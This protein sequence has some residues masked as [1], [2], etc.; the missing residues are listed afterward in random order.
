VPRLPAAVSSICIRKQ[1]WVI[2]RDHMQLTV[3]SCG[4]GCRLLTT[5]Q[6]TLVRAARS[7]KAAAVRVVAVQ[8]QHML[9]RLR[10][11]GCWLHCYID[12]LARL[13]THTTVHLSMPLPG[14]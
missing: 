9:L 6:P 3:G 14:V 8:V 13:P 7:G 1:Q 2:S 4:A 10:Q 5:A 12:L 11:A